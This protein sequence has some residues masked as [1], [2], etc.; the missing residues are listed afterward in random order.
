M[1]LTEEPQ[2]SQGKI[3]SQT[4]CIHYRPDT[5]RGLTWR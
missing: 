5:V 3:L 2:N 1:I 4:Y